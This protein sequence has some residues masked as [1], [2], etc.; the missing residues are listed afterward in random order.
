MKFFYKRLVK[1]DEFDTI[2][3]K[4]ELALKEKEELVLMVKDTIHHRVV[5]TVLTHLPEE[6]HKEFLKTFTKK[7][8]DEGI[9]DVLKEKIED[10]EE[11]IKKAVENVKTEILADL[12]SEE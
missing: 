6:N 8:H 7:P 3:E 5:E 2:F 10:I 9:L 1:I 4:H 12:E 11:K